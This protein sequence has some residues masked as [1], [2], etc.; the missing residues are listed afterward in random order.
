MRL[1]GFQEFIV[2]RGEQRQARAGWWRA[3][4][5]RDQRVI[6]AQGTSR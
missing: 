6:L 4:A 5:G 1:I 3:Q 2:A